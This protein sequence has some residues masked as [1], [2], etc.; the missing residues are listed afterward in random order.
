MSDQSRPHGHSFT[1]VPRAGDGATAAE[2]SLIKVNDSLD[3]ISTL[4]DHAVSGGR[5]AFV[6]DSPAYASG[7][8]AVIRAAALFETEEFEAHLGDVADEVRRA[9]I[10]MR[11][12]AAHSGYRS[13]NDDLFWQTLIVDLP[14]HLESWRAAARNRLTD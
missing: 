3:A 14:T 6:R 2:I 11:N 9:L 4:L 10:T 7:S 5:E 12:I 8:M 1:R 13:M